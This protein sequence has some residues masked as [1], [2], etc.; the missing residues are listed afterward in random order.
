MKIIYPRINTFVEKRFHCLF[1]KKKALKFKG[2]ASGG[3]VI[4]MKLRSIS[5]EAEVNFFRRAKI[6]R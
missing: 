6:S 3:F 2:F 1:S 5:S 4:E